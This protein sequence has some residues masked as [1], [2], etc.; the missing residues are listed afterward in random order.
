MAPELPP[1]PLPY[2]TDWLFEIGPVVSDGMGSAEISWR[3]FVAWQTI[4][5]VTL[6]PWE[7]SL[8]KR[9]SAEFLAEMH[10]AKNI[11]RPAPWVSEVERNREAISRKVSNAFKAMVQK[12]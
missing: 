12:G 3:D 2:I 4:S 7:A 11:D 5:G 6:M 1:N 8:L 9:L 10:E